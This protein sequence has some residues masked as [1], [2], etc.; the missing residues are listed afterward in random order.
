MK[1]DF[2]KFVRRN[3]NLA[4]YVENKKM[5]WQQFYEMYDLYGEDNEVWND[6]K[7]DNKGNIVDTIKDFLDLF[8]GIDLKTIQKVL[9][10]TSKAID[11]FKSFNT[12]E[13]QDNTEY[14][15]DKYKY[16]ED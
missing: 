10:T 5:T 2:K 7:E 4:K 9:S 15:D 13:K 8:K 16:F 12:S 3:P 11:A 6:F 1:E 14:A